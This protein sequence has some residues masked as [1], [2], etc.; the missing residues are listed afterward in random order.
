[1]NG[2]NQNHIICSCALMSAIMRDIINVFPDAVGARSRHGGLDGCLRDSAMFFIS[3]AWNYSGSLRRP[4]AVEIRTFM[5][6]I[7]AT[8]CEYSRNKNIHK[9]V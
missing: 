5:L 3:N 1:M 6:F 8:S 4:W 9:A 7:N 2:T